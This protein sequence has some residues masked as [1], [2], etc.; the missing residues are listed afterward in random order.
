MNKKEVTEI[1]KL[2]S[3]GS[4]QTFTENIQIFVNFFFRKG[5]KC[6]LKL[7]DFIFV[8]VHITAAETI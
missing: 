6:L 8:C 3:K 7:Y 4:G 1:K 5:E 2:F